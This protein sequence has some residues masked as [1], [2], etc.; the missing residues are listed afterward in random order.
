MIVMAVGMLLLGGLVTDGGRQL[1]AKLQAQAT[2]EE[3]ARAG[4]NMLDLRLLT[5][6]PPLDQDMAREAVDAYCAVARANDDRI[7]VCE[8]DGF[9]VSDNNK[10][11]FVSVRVTM[12]VKALLFGIIGQHELSVE[13]T[14]SA[15]PVQAIEDPLDKQFVP[16][17]VLPTPESPNYPSTVTVE[18]GEPPPPTSLL[19]LSNYT[20]QVCGQST[21]LPLTIA[22]SCTVTETVEPKPP[23]G[24]T[25]TTTIYSTRPTSVNPFPSVTP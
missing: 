24:T 21:V 25:I 11:E 2:A 22:V 20:T 14:E 15:T 6:Q 13:A 7:D 3:A 1:N 8:V 16:E 23:P 12:N 4:A 5:D 10:G 9:G 17:D 18:E 19:P